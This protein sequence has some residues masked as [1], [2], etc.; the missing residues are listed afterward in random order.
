MILEQKT[1]TLV[2]EDGESVQE[3]TNMQIDAESHVFL[4][5]M[6]S[7]FYSDGVGSLIRETASN[8]LDSHRQ[9]GVNEPIV[10]SLKS[11]SNGNYE[12]SVQDFGCGLDA[13]DVTNIISKY[14]KSTKRNT[15]N[16]LGAF[17]QLGRI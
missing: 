13:D 14:G 11:T 17:G 3:S 7:R 4:M 10:V 9:C 15:N 12:F 1:E 16:Q 2:L 6:L 5:R 8:A